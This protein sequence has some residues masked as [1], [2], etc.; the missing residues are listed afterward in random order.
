MSTSELGDS[1]KND[2]P[3]PIAEPRLHRFARWIAHNNPLHAA[4]VAALVVALVMLVTTYGARL[5]EIELRHARGK[6]AIAEHAAHTLERETVSSLRLTALPLGWALRSALLQNQL[7]DA[8]AY[9]RR[10]ILEPQVTR[11]LLLDPKGNVWLASDGKQVGQ[12]AA[13]VVP[14]APLDGPE[15]ALVQRRTEILV[16]VPIMGF[17]RRLGTLVFGYERSAGLGFG[18]E[19]A[20]SAMLDAAPAPTDGPADAATPAVTTGSGGER[21]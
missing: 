17:D 16:V 10:M 2:A 9:L 3:G 12:A 15:P 18:G 13:T 5:Q 21:R 14:E 19:A 4:V 7:A 20:S 11:A 8:E 6:A 1:D